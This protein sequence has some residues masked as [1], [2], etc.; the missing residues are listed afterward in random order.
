[1]ILLLKIMLCSG[2]HCQKS[3]KLK[4]VLYQIA[5]KASMSSQGSGAGIRD[6]GLGV[7]VQGSGFGGEG[8]GRGFGFRVLGLGSSVQGL[9]S[10]V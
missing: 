1:M 2:L 8:V 6:G 3:F 4:H 7:R 10:G 5:G 9:G